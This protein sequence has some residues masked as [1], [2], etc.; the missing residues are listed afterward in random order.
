MADMLN[1][2]SLFDLY[3]ECI[4]CIFVYLTLNGRTV[5][6]MMMMMVAVKTL[7]LFINTLKSH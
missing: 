6:V 5:T 7:K 2:I 1:L 4:M 3:G